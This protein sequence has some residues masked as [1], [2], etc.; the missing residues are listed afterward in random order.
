[1]SPTERWEGNGPSYRDVSD[2]AA[3]VRA[4]DG[5]G[6]RWWITP[7]V[8]IKTTG[9][10]TSWAVSIEVWTIGASKNRTWNASAAYGQNGA[11][12]TVPAAMLATLRAYEQK[13]EDE[14]VAAEAQ[15]MF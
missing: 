8:Y 12:K 7:P 13:R 2:Y 15:A 11:W 9:R 10:W 4:R 14:R 5:V 1:M 3:D 6:V